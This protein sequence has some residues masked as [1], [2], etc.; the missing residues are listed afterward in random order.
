MDNAKNS[1]TNFYVLVAFE[2]RLEF[3]WGSLPNRARVREYFAKMFI[4]MARGSGGK[5]EEGRAIGNTVTAIVVKMFV[6][7]WGEW[8]SFVEDM[9]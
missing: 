7:G 6:Y 3:I 2:Q 8:G 1:K 9:I 5:G 4:E